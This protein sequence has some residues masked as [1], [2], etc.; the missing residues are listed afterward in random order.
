MGRYKGM[1]DSW[2]VL[3]EFVE[4]HKPGYRETDFTRVL[5]EGLPNQ[6]F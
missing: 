4:V 6:T 1:I 5:G 2:D 3:N